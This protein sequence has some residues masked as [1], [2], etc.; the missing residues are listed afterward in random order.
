[1]GRYDELYLR[2]GARL[3]TVW[4]NAIVDALNELADKAFS[5]QIRSRVLSMSPVPGG[6]GSYGSKV[7]A[8]PPQYRLWVIVGAKITWIGP[9]QDGEESK[10]RITVTFSDSSTSYIE[11]SSSSPQ[12]IWLSSMEIFTLWKDSVGVQKIEV[13]SSSNKDSTSIG[14][15]ATIY[16]IE[17]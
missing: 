10:V 5:S 15:I 4:L 1:M 16:C 11:K 8:T 9:F 2:P 6:G 7:S 14:T 3:S 13:D 12:E 17:A